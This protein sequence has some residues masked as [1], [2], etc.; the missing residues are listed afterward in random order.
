MFSKMMKNEQ[1]IM[2]IIHT[3]HIQILVKL[4]KSHNAPT[5]LYCNTIAVGL[6]TNCTGIISDHYRLGSTQ[7]NTTLHGNITRFSL[8]CCC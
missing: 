3:K 1:I 6:F 7:H 2:I 5:E 8:F 4:L